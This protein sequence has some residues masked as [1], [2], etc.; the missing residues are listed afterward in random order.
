MVD[1]T[2]LTRANM[3]A[4]IGSSRASVRSVSDKHLLQ[5]IEKAD[6]F[7]SETPSDFERFQMVGMSSVPL[8]QKEE[9]QNQNKQTDGSGSGEEGMNHN[10]PQ[11]ESAEAI[12]LYLNG[13]R[14]HP[15]AFMDDRRVR[16]FNMKEGESS[17]YA[18]SGTGQMLLHTDDGTYIVSL[19]NKPYDTSSGEGG[20]Q[21][22]GESEEEKQRVVSIRH[23]TKDKQSREIKEGEDPEDHVHE[24]KPDQVNTEVELNGKTIKIKDGE[25]VI[26]VYSKEDKSWK[27]SG[28]K[29][30]DIEVDEKITVTA[31][32][33]TI[34]STEKMLI[35]CMGEFNL[36]GKPLH[37]NG[38]GPIIPPFTVPG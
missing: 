38:G 2:S 25:T 8:K 20:S 31:P 11:G 5:E 30:L 32:D 24:G 26:A 14:S 35:E 4:R 1:R 16:P 29:T 34:E 10:Q 36:K 7:H 37:V 21:S 15:V 23:V 22:G 17:Y 3:T 12:M 9:K 33:V 28:F 6:V 27:F 19:N 13:Q 18:A